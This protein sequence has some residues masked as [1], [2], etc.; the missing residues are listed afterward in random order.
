MRTAL[1]IILI[2]VVVVFLGRLSWAYFQVKFDDAKKSITPL[3]VATTT[4]ELV[5]PGITTPVTSSS[6]SSIIKVISTSS[7]S[8]KVVPPTPPVSAQTK[9]LAFALL[10]LSNP[11]NVSQV[12]TLLA[13]TSIDGVALQIGWTSMETSDDVFDWTTLDTALKTAKDSGK[14]VTLHIFPGGPLGIAQW[15]KNAGVE[16][17][18]VSFRGRTREEVLPWDQTF[19]SQYSQFLNSLAEHLSSAGYLS[20]VARISVGVPV[21][22]MDLVACRDNTLASVYSYNRDTYLSSWKTMIDAHATAFP[23]IKKFISAP[24]GLICYPDRDTQFF[25]DVMDYAF[26]K[27]G[28]MFVPFAADLTSVGS[29]RM[30]PYTNMVSSRG[31]GYQPIWSSTNDPSNR[32]KGVYPE[33]LLQSTCKAVADGADYVEIYAV[34]VSNIDATIQKGV[35]AVHDSSLCK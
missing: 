25:T 8:M 30:K 7:S 5:Q 32:V 6:T 34:D 4:P 15:L 13:N 19:L 11:Q 23:S 9:S 10:S 28:A 22:E 35:R 17:Y 31:L 33:K 26:K 3:L 29:D 20:T 21:G 16:T 2:I 18:S 12:S 27:S 1:K 24:V 14:R